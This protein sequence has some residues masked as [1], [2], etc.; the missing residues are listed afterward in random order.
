MDDEKW[1]EVDKQWFEDNL[2]TEDVI[3]SPYRGIT[4]RQGICTHTFKWRYGS[5]AAK[6]VSGGHGN[7]K[8]DKYYRVA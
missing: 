4:F 3:T 6:H 5:I 7:N 1:V 8:I 2:Y